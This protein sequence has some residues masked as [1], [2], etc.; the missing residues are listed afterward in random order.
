MS[1]IN[2][3]VKFYS[4]PELDHPNSMKPLT[5][6]D[7]RTNF[8]PRD[9]RNARTAFPFPPPRGKQ[10]FVR[11]PHTPLPSPSKDARTHAH[12]NVMGRY[13]HLY[14]SVCCVF[15]TWLGLVVLAW[16]ACAVHSVSVSVSKQHFCIP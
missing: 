6:R 4:K 15:A 7:P 12:V 16:L 5:Q 13:R 10:A 2:E 11:E 8:P 1:V 14:A 3:Q 9:P